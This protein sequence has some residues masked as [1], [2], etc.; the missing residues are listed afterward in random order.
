MTTPHVKSDLELHTVAVPHGPHV[1]LGSLTSAHGRS[2]TQ[3]S[4]GG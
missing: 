3:P 4:L 2:D 1:G